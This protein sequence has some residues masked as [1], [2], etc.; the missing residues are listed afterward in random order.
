[1]S[2]VKTGEEAQI[3]VIDG[4]DKLTI[5]IPKHR[6]VSGVPTY[7]R[8]KDTGAKDLDKP[9]GNALI[10]STH[11]DRALPSGLSLSMNLVRKGG[12]RGGS[13]VVK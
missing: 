6:K 10:A 1:M 13:F 8:N 2:E 3:T 11:G 12:A 4:Q 5:E 9:T 7:K